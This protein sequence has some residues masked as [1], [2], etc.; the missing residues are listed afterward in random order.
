[1]LD[2]AAGEELLALLPPQ[3]VYLMA[4]ELG[5]DQIPELLNMATPEQWTAFFD[6]DC[7]DGDRFDARKAPRL[8]GGAAGRGGVKGRRHPPQMD[9][10]LL[11][12]MLHREVQIHSGPEEMEDEAAMAEGRRRE[13]GYVLDYR[14]R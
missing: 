10:E 2:A 6:F 11:V 1:M 8:A 12:L 7:W 3:D 13:C 14:R 9:F 5:A 4:R